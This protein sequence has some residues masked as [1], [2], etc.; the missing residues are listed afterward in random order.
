MLNIVVFVFFFFQCRDTLAYE[1]V[2]IC[3]EA[4]GGFFRPNGDQN[5]IKQ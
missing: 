3:G 5:A 4:C 1:R 2:N